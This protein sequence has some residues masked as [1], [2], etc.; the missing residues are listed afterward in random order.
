MNQTARKFV[1]IAL[2]LVLLLVLTGC[3]RN[4]LDPQPI[5]G[6]Q[7]RDILVWPIAGLLWALGKSV[8]FSN[9]GLMVVFATLIVR[10]IAWPIYAKTNDMSLKM[11]L[12]GPEQAKIEEKY[13]DKT[14][15]ESLQRK[16]METMQLYKKYGIGLGGC[17][18]PLVQLPLFIA[19]YETLRRVPLT[20]GEQFTLNFGDFDSMFFGINLFQ[21]QE[22][23][24]WQK[25]G[26]WILAGLVGITQVIA[27]FLMSRRQKKMKE[28]T[29]AGVPMYRRP[30][31]TDQQKQTERTMKF[32][33]YGMSVMMV[34]F[35]L[36]S[37][38]ALGLYW[39]IGNVYSTLQSEL[40][41]KRNKGRLEKLKSKY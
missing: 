34:V 19:F 15:Q 8:A 12:M 11:Q 20:I 36:N 26:I 25:Y 24:G 39:L 28:E 41:G 35:V 38:A 14:D 13:K 5:Q 10:T 9:Y 30:P 23:G 6:F 2:L 29:Q 37:P 21:T 27:Q 40:S 1:G 32:M 7:F 4:A 22:A 33:M 17:L 16:Q 3:N 18:M 31:Q